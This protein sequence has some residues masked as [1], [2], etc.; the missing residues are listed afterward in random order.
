MKNG[1]DLAM[2]AVLKSPI[3]DAMIFRWA[4]EQL[5]DESKLQHFQSTYMSKKRQKGTAHLLNLIAIIGIGGIHR[6]YLGDIGL[7]IAHLLTAGFCWIGTIVDIINI[8]QRVNDANVRI[9]MQT[10]QVVRAMR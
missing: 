7:G 9:A 8:N 3:E 6:F 10:L 4:E 1:V 2:L 5:E